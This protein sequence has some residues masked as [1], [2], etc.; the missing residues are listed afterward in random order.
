MYAECFCG[1]RS[2]ADLKRSP[3]GLALSALAAVSALCGCSKKPDV[4]TGDAADRIRKVALAYVQY[5]GTNRGV[6][7]A[8]KATLLKFMAKQ[9]QITEAEAEEAFVS[10]RDNLPW[11]IRWKQR[12]LEAP[13]GPNPPK[14]NVL[15]YE[16]QGADGTRYIADGQLSV[17][18]LPPELFQHVAPEEGASGG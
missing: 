13:V 15:V 4:P 6:G 1:R 17:K 14:A 9:N 18:E 7:P 8:D 16:Q 12:P 3:I 2:V 11:V 10:P 5:A